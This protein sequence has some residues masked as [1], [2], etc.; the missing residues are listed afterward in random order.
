MGHSFIALSGGHGL[1]IGRG[2]GGVFVLLISYKL[3][4]L[5][6]LS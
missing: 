5:L 4:N 2:A 3:L 6:Q 1:A